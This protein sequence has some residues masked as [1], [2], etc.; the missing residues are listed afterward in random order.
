[1][2]FSLSDRI[3]EGKNVL[4]LEEIQCQMT[5]LFKKYIYICDK[6]GAKYYMAFGSL[7]GTVR[8]QGFI[9]WDDDLDVFMFRKDYD[10]FIEYCEKQSEDIYPLKVL[11]PEKDKDYPFAIARFTDTSFQLVTNIHKDIE[12]G[13]FL[14]IYPLD[15]AGTEETDDYSKVMRKKH[16]LNKCVIQAIRRNPFYDVRG[17][18]YCITRL[19]IY[20][21]SKIIGKDYF[22]RK[23]CMMKDTYKRYDSTYVGVLIWDQIKDRWL[24]E[25]FENPKVAEFCGLKVNIPANYDEILKKNYG[26][27]MTL[28]PLDK[29][30]PHHHYYIYKK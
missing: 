12:M 2:K 23:M 29:R 22:I 13:I 25:G 6:I 18:K 15:G 28:P 11:T 30:N 4:T 19:P 16:F 10:A 26:D 24:K 14:D 20:C 9:P 5:E 27:Y 8:H 3:P 17:M 1:M 21:I 7:L